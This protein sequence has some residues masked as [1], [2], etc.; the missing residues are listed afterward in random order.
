LDEVFKS[1]P[2]YAQQL[3]EELKEQ[4]LLD[5]KSEHFAAELF[6]R[7]DWQ[8]DA[9]KRAHFAAIFQEMVD[10]YKPRGAIEVTMLEVLAVNY[11]LWRYWIMEHLQ[12]ATTEARQESDDYK[13]W[14]QR[15]N[16]HKNIK[17]G[18]QTRQ[19]RNSPQYTAGR[20]D[21]LYQCEADAIDHAAQLADRFR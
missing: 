5:F 2:E 14:R 19:A 11:F 17:V 7:T 3:W 16:N 21:L 13:E 18:R 10:E 6:E 12:C 20:W 9:W 4:A 8:K 15:E 1:N